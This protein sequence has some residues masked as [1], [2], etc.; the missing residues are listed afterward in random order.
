MV[1]IAAPHKN[2]VVQR[3]LAADVDPFAIVIGMGD[4]G[5]EVPGERAGAQQLQAHADLKM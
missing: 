2:L 4:V 1:A 3:Q 5:G